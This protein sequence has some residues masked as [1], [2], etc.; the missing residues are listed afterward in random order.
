MHAAGLLLNTIAVATIFSSV[1]A[2]SPGQAANCTTLPDK[3]RLG[4]DL[5]NIRGSL[6]ACPGLCSST[7]ACAT[8]VYSNHLGGTCWLKSRIGTL[9]DKPGVTATSCGYNKPMVCNDFK[10]IDFVSMDIGNKPGKMAGDCCD[11]CNQFTGCTAYAWS[12]FNGGTCWLKKSVG[13]TEYKPGVISSSLLPLYGGVCA[14]EYNTDFVGNDI[15]NKPSADAGVCCGQCKATSGCKAY[16]WT[17]HNG[18]TCWM[19]NG[20]GATAAKGGATSATI[21]IF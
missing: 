18:G 11:I 15:G 8:W 13:Q 3:D 12:D 2:Q 16:T 20:K 6:A 9:I 21:A 4:F 1:T 7:P 19:K 14:A 5:D 10:D 17:N